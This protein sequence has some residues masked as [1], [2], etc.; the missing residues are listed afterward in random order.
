MI[1]IAHPLS[2]LAIKA[3]AWAISKCRNSKPFNSVT[4][5]GHSWWAKFKKCHE[6]EVTL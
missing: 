4:G 1:S 3:F 2:V 5:P 6:K